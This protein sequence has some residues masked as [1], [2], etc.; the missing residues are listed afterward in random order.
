MALDLQL[1]IFAKTYVIMFNDGE[2]V[3]KKKKIFLAVL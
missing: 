1:F 3:I 2:V